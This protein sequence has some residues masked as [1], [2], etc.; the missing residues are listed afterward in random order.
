MTPTL[1]LPDAPLAAS[2]IYCALPLATLCINAPAAWACEALLTYAGS[3]R[4]ILLAGPAEAMLQPG[5]WHA[6]RLE[7]PYLVRYELVEGP[8]P[9]LA[10]GLEARA[11]DARRTLLECEGAYLAPRGPL[12][13]AQR[14][15]QLAEGLRAGLLLSIE[16]ALAPG[17]GLR[18]E[19]RAARRYPF[20]L[21]VRLR[22]G[23]APWPGTL[24]DVSEGGTGI[25]IP[26]PVLEAP[27]VAALIRTHNSGALELLCDDG[28]LTAR[29]RIRRVVAAAGGVGVGLEVGGAEE[30]GRLL[31]RL[32][33][34]GLWAG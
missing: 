19:R 3:A 11:L 18:G 22:T 10:F 25:L 23:D 6:V 26:A 2:A 12:P 9:G 34:R 24:S 20:A 16:D 33:A 32:A 13:A 29:V 17:G 4:E 28:R 27:S 15:R 5:R 30:R 14:A 31:R 7:R 1:E 8:L 21:P